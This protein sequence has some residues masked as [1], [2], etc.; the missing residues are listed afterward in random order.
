MLNHKAL[1]A[2]VSSQADPST[3]PCKGHAQGCG[4][5]HITP[6][7][8]TLPVPTKHRAEQEGDRW[9]DSTRSSEH[10]L[11]NFSVPTRNAYICKV[12]EVSTETMVIVLT[13]QKYKPD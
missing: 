4:R 2:G 9:A 5:L 7:A 13:W 8:A 3:E 1:K 6:S 11:T 10:R 12:Q